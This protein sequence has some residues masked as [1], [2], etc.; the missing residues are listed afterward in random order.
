M[1]QSVWFVLGLSIGGGTL[2]LAAPGDLIYEAPREVTKITAPQ[3][4]CYADCAIAAGAWSGARADMVRAC[5]S[6]EP[7]GFVAVTIGLKT[8][9]PGDVPANSGELKVVGRV[10]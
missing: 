6:R 2:A 10:E 9:A 4:A 5:A 7:G 1:K 8:V 3:A